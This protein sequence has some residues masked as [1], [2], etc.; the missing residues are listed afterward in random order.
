M[1]EKESKKKSFL[2]KFFQVLSGSPIASSTENE[3]KGKFAPVEKEALDVRFVRN[4]TNSGGFFLYCGEMKEV[5]SAIEDIIAEHNL[6]AIGSPDEALI[7][8]LKKGGVSKVQQ[9]LDA[10]DTVCT[11]CE[12]LVALNGSIMINEFQT[13]G[14]GIDAMPKYHI[15]IA[16]TSQLVE[17]LSGAMS[18][19][20]Q[21]YRNNRPMQITQLKAPMDERVKLASADP[22]KDRTLFLLL[23]EDFSNA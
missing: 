20:N 4:F 17:N 14:V 7:S 1:A 23:T 12:A 6:S 5:F 22:N 13:K 15:V 18:K 11:Y 16:K 2:G 10:C 3:E 19:I 21:L 8:I 9:N